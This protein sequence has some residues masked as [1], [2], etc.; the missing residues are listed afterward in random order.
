[1]K[2]NNELSNADSK[3]NLNQSKNN[4]YQDD[5]FEDSVSL[6]DFGKDGKLKDN[7]K[8]KIIPENEFEIDFDNNIDININKENIS[9]NKYDTDNDCNVEN[10]I[11]SDDD[12][13]KDVGNVLDDLSAKKYNKISNDINKVL[14]GGDI[15]CLFDENIKAYGNSNNN[16]LNDPNSNDFNKENGDDNE[17]DDPFGD[18]NLNSGIKNNKKVNQVKS[19]GLFEQKLNSNHTITNNSKQKNPIIDD[20]GFEIDQTKN[21]FESTELPNLNLNKLTIG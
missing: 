5:V 1:M 21:V 16:N 12:P 20:F 3:N 11:L 14:G 8:N 10:G 7:I 4:R 13:F 9:S 19:V 18:D 2:E 17:D 6:D 15:N